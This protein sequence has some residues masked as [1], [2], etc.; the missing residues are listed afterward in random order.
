MPLMI[1]A[2][3]VSTSRK[4]QQI[5]ANEATY[6]F[7]AFFCSS[8]WI[9]MDAELYQIQGEFYRIVQELHSVFR[10]AFFLQK[11]TSLTLLSG[12]NVSRDYK[13]VREGIRAQF[14]TAHF[15][16]PLDS[17]HLQSVTLLVLK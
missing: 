15:F 14:R 16:V 13:L 2:Y 17:P 9:P 11:V 1:F 4:Q 10:L 3:V 7:T 8:S 5:I 12:K 6:D